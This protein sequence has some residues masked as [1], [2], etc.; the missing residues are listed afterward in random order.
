MGNIM[1]IKERE[2]KLC[3]K[4]E[5]LFITGWHQENYFSNWNIKKGSFLWK[6]Y[7]PQTKNDMLPLYRKNPGHLVFFKKKKYEAKHF[8]TDHSGEQVESILIH[9]TIMLN[10]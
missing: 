4:Q 1:S 9:F 2:K 10:H 6:R 8:L 7:K 5:G 3:A